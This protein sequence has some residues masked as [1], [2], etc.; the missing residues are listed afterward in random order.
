MKKNMLY[1]VLIF[2]I[3]SFIIQ[4]KGEGKSYPLIKEGSENCSL[5]W[6]DTQFE[7]E[8]KLITSMYSLGI[9]R[10]TTTSNRPAILNFQLVNNSVKSF[11]IVYSEVL[12]YFF[13]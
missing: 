12:I 8:K 6:Y 10:S 5:S 7:A 2:C 11:T 9:V 1:V 3:T 4:V 13:E